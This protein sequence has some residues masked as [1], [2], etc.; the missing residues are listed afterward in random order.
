MCPVSLNILNKPVRIDGILFDYSS[1]LGLPL[2]SNGTRKHP[3]T[4]ERFYLDQIQPDRDCKTEIETLI[5]QYEV[6]PTHG[7]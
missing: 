3:T 2:A 4:Q 6:M 1:L 7:K 5:R